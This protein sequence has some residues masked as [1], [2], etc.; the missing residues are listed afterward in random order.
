MGSGMAKQKNKVKS[1]TDCYKL[2]EA[3]GEGGFSIVKL[4][5]RYNDSK[6]VAVKIINR[7]GL[8]DE[9]ELCVIQ[10]VNIL[11]KLD[12]PNIIHTYDFFEEPKFYYVVLEF[13]GGG[14]LFDRIVKKTTYTEK[15]A[16]DLVITLLGTLNYL[17]D[18]N[19]IHRDLKPEN[20]LLNTKEDDA[21]VI[22]VDFGFAIEVDGFNVNA[23]YGTPGYIAPEI[24]ENVPY[25]KPIDLWSFGVILY[26]LLG[27][28]PPFFDENQRA[29]FRK[30]M[31]GSY[32]F[33][34]DR[35]S[36]VSDEAKDLIRGLLTVNPLKRLTVDQAMNHSWV[37]K[38]ANELAAKSLQQSLLE[39]SKFQAKKIFQKN[40]K[41]V[42]MLN[43]MKGN[44]NSA[45][46]L[47]E[48]ANIGKS[49]KKD[50]RLIGKLP[51]G[52]GRLSMKLPGEED[53]NIQT[54]GENT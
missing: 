22:L 13:V 45:Q 8:Q 32:E 19:I 51:E 25:G 52:L 46:E 3:L 1:V 15:E 7:H 14:E 35:W 20:L 40:V 33:H 47:L 43:R 4:G 48:D 50:T 49:D 21:N 29:L 37:L 18:N 9:D 38:D 53:D 39:L 11:K 27:G 24:L 36:H 2:G 41:K 16:R 31:R 23:P 6:K 10:E 17:H 12:H 26:I 42:M 5:T 30:I 44:S 34:P 28:Y 54:Q